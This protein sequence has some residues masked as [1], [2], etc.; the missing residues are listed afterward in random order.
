MFGTHSTAYQQDGDP[1]A[2][3]SMHAAVADV[4]YRIGR[5]GFAIAA[6]TIAVALLFDWLER[7]AWTPV[8]IY[9]GSLS[10]L[11]A[12]AALLLLWRPTM[13][14]RL[15]RIVL[16]YATLAFLLYFWRVFAADYSERTYIAIGLLWTPLLYLA[17]HVLYSSRY[18]LLYSLGLFV[19]T[20]SIGGWHWLRAVWL[21]H[22]PFPLSLLINVY[23]ASVLVMLLCHYVR[24]LSERMLSVEAAAKEQAMHAAQQ[25]ASRYQLLFETAHDAVIVIESQQNIV[26]EAN[27]LASS[28]IGYDKSQLLGMPVEQLFYNEKDAACF[29]EASGRL[30]AGY[31]RGQQ[32]QPIPVHF[33]ARLV[34]HEPLIQGVFHGWRSEAQLRTNEALL[35]A[36]F[37]KSPAAVYLL[38]L[39]DGV[40]L[41]ANQAYSCITGYSLENLIGNHAEALGMIDAD[42]LVARAAAY[43]RLRQGETT[44][45][46]AVRVRCADG[47]LRHLLA[48]AEPISIDGEACAIVVSLDVSEQ[49]RISEALR[50]SEANLRAILESSDDAFILFDTDM[51]AIMLNQAAQDR[52][53]QAFGALLS[54]GMTL[55]T[56]MSPTAY[57][58]ILEDM[59]GVLEANK[60]AF[61]RQAYRRD[62]SAYWVDARYHPVLDSQGRVHNIV[63]HSRD[64]SA[65]KQAETA[66]RLSE[67]NL[68]T[69]IDNNDNAFLLL[70]PS[71]RVKAFNRVASLR[72]E[73]LLGRPLSVGIDMHSLLTAK[74]DNSFAKDMAQ[75]LAGQAVRFERRN[76]PKGHEA[77]WVEVFY[78]PVH[79]AQGQVISVVHYIRDISER[80]RS[81]ENLQ[82]AL[83]EKDTL[84]Q[85]VHH[86][87]KNNLQIVSSLLSMQARQA[88]DI[89]VR[90]AFEESRDRIRAMAAVHERLYHKGNVASVDFADYL[91]ALVSSMLRFASQPIA[92]H[93]ELEPIHLDLDTSIPCGLIVSEAVSNVLK[94]AFSEA[95]HRAASLHVQLQ[96]CEGY[97]IRL[98]LRDNGQ[99]L[100]KRIDP[101]RS[102]T[103]G[104]SIM[105][106]LAKQLRGELRIEA[107]IAS[108]PPS[109]Q[110]L[111][112]TLTFP[113][114]E[115]ETSE[116]KT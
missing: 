5:Y 35:T 15:E 54:P 95:K 60:V 4:K 65:Y 21:N 43:E 16:G 94:Y 48:S 69:I 107:A 39:R 76:Q 45:N 113:Y 34:C 89:K 98:Q 59:S 37:D 30:E 3:L 28:L 2:V 55:R 92:L 11:C 25:S 24:Y 66:L 109:Q 77:Y 116:I 96:R 41:Q 33:R 18:A 115:I 53:Q 13:L 62:G 105:R 90:Q 75:A 58:Q 44:H 85:E 80:K 78:Y 61:E 8:Y 14:A 38:R 56:L 84:L 114:P 26:V 31:V 97:W 106:A 23:G 20:L 47:S 88:A 36:L 110:G 57:Q 86:R 82:Q 40:Y 64:I 79:D 29:L 7:Q 72:T 73:R 104:F 71:G 63:F 12:L 70:D 32:G 6:L 42:D 108:A 9:M 19:A 101:E 93:A 51:R 50:L 81:E 27:T 74:P 102:Q 87:V 83:R 91:Q 103:L 22:E 52:S 49:Q 112:V 100:S 10:A 67:A 46:F 99:G 17:A 68:R 111:A 1:A